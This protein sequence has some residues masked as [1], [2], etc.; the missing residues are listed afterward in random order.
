MSWMYID[1]RSLYWY[2]RT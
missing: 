1:H 2:H